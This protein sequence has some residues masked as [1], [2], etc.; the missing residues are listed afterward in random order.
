MKITIHQPQYMPWCGYF[1]KMARADLFVFLDDVQ[2]KKNEWQNRNRIRNADG[3]QWLSVPNSYSFPQLINQVA[4]RNDLD[5][6]EKHLRSLAMCYAHAP[7]YSQY[8]ELFRPF[9]GRPQTSMDRV[10]ADSALLLKGILGITTPV[11]YSSRYNFEGTATQRLVDICAHFKADTYL[12]GAGGR[13]YMDESLFVKSG[14]RL[15]YQDFTC[16]RYGQHWAKAAQDFIPSLS[17]LDLI[18]NCGPS[19]LKILMGDA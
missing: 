4:V 16:P 14:I 19:S 12:A 6:P 2:F 10:A 15:E 8:I 3:W 11:D 7:Y 17:A 9:F 13:E 18:F 5:W 1:H